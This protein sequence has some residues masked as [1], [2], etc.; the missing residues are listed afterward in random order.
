MLLVSRKW[1]SE[2]KETMCISDSWKKLQDI[3]VVA[4]AAGETAKDGEETLSLHLA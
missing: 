4:V 3:S 1:Y 2:G